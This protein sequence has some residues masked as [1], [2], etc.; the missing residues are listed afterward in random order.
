MNRPTPA[1]VRTEIEACQPGLRAVASRTDNA[2]RHL[3]ATLAELGGLTDAEAETAAAYYLRHRLAK[4][5]R[6]N[7]TSSVVHGAFLDAEVIRRAV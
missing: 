7:G 6:I 1:A 3:R 2:L 5:D 4:L